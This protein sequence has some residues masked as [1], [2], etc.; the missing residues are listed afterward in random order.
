MIKK[1]EALANWMEKEGHKEIIPSDMFTGHLT[2]LGMN[3]EGAYIKLQTAKE[4]S[5]RRAYSHCWSP[6]WH[7]NQ[8]MAS[9]ELTAGILKK[10]RSGGKKN[11]LSQLLSQ[12]QAGKTGTISATEEL[13]NDDAISTILGLE[14]ALLMSC[15][16]DK[17]LAEQTMGRTHSGV[18][19]IRM[20]MASTLKNAQECKKLLGDC[21][22]DEE[23]ER[24]LKQWGRSH[25]R[26]RYPI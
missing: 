20:A 6:D 10:R 2:G 22:S 23:R 13:L 5:Q 18:K 19:V 4:E 1:D 8:M 24:L 26:E 14:L 15:P 7:P 17:S 3:Y 11:T 25:D 12:T 9:V 16:S 21:Q